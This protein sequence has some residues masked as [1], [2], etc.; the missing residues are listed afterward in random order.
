[1]TSLITRP[2]IIAFTRPAYWG[3]FSEASILDTDHPY[4]PDWL[5]VTAPSVKSPTWLRNETLLPWEVV[6]SRGWP[7]NARGNHH[8]GSPTLDRD[9]ARRDRAGYGRRTMG[10]Q[11][12]VWMWSVAS[13]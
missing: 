8:S 2:V 1:M 12:L 5:P 3:A 13:R 7:R 4:E 9:R 6:P 11:V 10:W